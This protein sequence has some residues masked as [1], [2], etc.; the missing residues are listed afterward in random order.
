VPLDGGAFS[1]SAWIKCTLGENADAGRRIF[2]FAGT[3]DQGED[4]AGYSDDIFL[5][6]WQASDQTKPSMSYVIY[7]GSQSVGFVDTPNIFPLNI[8]VLVQL[9]H[10][11]DKTVSI[12]LDGVEKVSE[13]SIPLPNVVNRI[14]KL[15]TFTGSMKEVAFFN[16][17]M[18]AMTVAVE[19]G[20]SLT[21]IVAAYDGVKVWSDRDDYI[22]P[23]LP[24]LLQGKL[25]AQLTH[26]VT[27]GTIL[28]I[29][30]LPSMDLY[31]AIDSGLVTSLL[32]IEID[33]KLVAVGW[34]KTSDSFQWLNPNGAEAGIVTLWTTA[35]S[36]SGINHVPSFSDSLKMS[37]FVG[38][39][40]EASSMRID[41]VDVKTI[42]ALCSCLPSTTKN[43]L[44]PCTEIDS[45]EKYVVCCKQDCPD[46]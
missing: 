12:Y 18:P 3:N 44:Q 46:G 36:N 40:A 31:L 2:N 8:W 9:I 29:T 39:S 20:S 24:L 5:K 45:Y 43:T 30:T 22:Y 27:T 33:Q 17:E 25:M 11:M 32:G 42:T 19:I 28:K 16:G 35:Q 13:S 41:H 1:F 4:V 34:K 10:R 15:K 14:W 21:N 7:H 37:V 23:N 6:I 26:R 38:Y